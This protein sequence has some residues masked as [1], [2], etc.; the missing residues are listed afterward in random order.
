MKFIIENGI[1][2]KHKIIWFIDHLIDMRRAIP[3]QRNAIKR[4]QSD[5]DYLKN[6]NINAT[7]HVKINSIKIVR[8]VRK[9]G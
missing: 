9:L 6:N 7:K 4:W 8:N 5:S 2:D 1:M 3:N